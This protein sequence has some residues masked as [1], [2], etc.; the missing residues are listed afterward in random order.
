M[1]RK[2]LAW[3]GGATLC[4]VGVAAVLYATGGA[5]RLSNT[6]GHSDSARPDVTRTGA[7][8]CS[9]QPDPCGCTEQRAIELLSDCFADK[10]FETARVASPSC[11]NPGLLG[12]KAE[13]LA[14]TGQNALARSAAESLLHADPHSRF[15]RR[16]LAIVRLNE[17]DLDG[18]ETALVALTAEDPNDADSLY[19]ASLVNRARDRYREARQGFLRVLRLNKRHIDARFNL[20]T[21]TAALGARDEAQHHLDLLLQI[22]PVGDPRLSLA[23]IAVGEASATNGRQAAAL[24]VQQ[25]APLP[26]ASTVRP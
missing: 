20:A 25:A 13:A 9:T 4:F 14:A 19:Y 2:Q 6:P 16:A 11:K 7:A 26:S 15:G 22:T 18:A 24:I 17:R 1:A 5:K 12:V 8:N 3:L 23:K 10:A 21:M